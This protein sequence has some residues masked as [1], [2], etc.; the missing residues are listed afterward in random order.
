MKTVA[1]ISSEWLDA[2]SLPAHCSSVPNGV[3]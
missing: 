2:V 1:D 3:R